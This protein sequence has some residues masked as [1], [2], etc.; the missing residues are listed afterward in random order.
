ML[1]RSG[2]DDGVMIF[3]DGARVVNN[4]GLHGFRTRQGEIELEPGTHE[5]EIR[6]FENTGRAGLKV[7]WEGPDTDGLAVLKPDPPS[8]AP[9]NGSFDL[10]LSLEDA[11]EAATVSLSGLPP[12]TVVAS[13]DDTAQVD[14]TGVIDLDGWSLDALG[15]FPPLAFEGEI[16]AEILVEDVA[17]NGA[18]VTHATPLTLVVGEADS[19]SPPPDAEFEALISGDAQ[20]RGDASIGWDALSA[21]EEIDTEAED[22]VMSETPLVFADADAVSVNIDTYERV[23]W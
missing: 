20:A 22:D 2:G 3:V 7:E 8:E 1:F 19:A 16:G 23:D 10:A 14:D 15:I 13:G 18:T 17:F 12:G 5:V 6:Y 4:D 9:Q 11:S 21:K